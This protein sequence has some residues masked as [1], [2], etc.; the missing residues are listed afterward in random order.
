MAAL[1]TRRYGV[2]LLATMRIFDSTI[3]SIKDGTKK[4]DEDRVN[5][6]KTFTSMS[7]K[8]KKR[9]GGEDYKKINKTYSEAIRK[10]KDEKIVKKLKE[11][12][13]LSQIKKLFG[14]NVLHEEQYHKMRVLFDDLG[15]KAEPFEGFWGFSS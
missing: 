12:R 9:A 10:I 4:L 6:L 2:N 5:I 14:K 7:A 11:A 13:T 1:G 3:R 8:D 15:Y